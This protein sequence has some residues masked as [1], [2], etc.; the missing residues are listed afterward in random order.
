MITGF[1][2][3]LLTAMIATSGRLITGV[4]VDAAHRAEAEMVI[5]DPDQLVA[6]RL[7]AARGVG[8]AHDLARDLPHATRPRHC[9]SPGPS[10]RSAVWVAMPMWIAP[11]RVID[12][13][14]VVDRSR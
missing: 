1:S 10:G 6:R 9:G 4:E 3:T 7:A 5:V 14:I 8:E 13:R 11:E 12:A 2:S